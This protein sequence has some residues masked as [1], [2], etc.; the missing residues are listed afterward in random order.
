MSTEYCPHCRKVTSMSSTVTLRDM[1]A[2]DGTFEVLTT[3]T[4]HCSVCLLFVRSEE[5]LPR[6]NEIGFVKERS[7]RYGAH[8]LWR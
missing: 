4:Y 2:S 1:T 6:E 3:R 5:E 8:A 7:A